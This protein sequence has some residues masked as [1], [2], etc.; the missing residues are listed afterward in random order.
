[1]TYV[2]HTVICSTRP[3]RV[4]SAIGR[5]AHQFALDH[6]KFQAEL[7]DLAAFNLP[8]FDEPAHPRLRQYKHEHTQAWSR[9]VQSADAFVFVTPE[10]NSGPPPSL[11]NALDYLVA[12]WQ[13]KPASFVA[14]GGISGGLRGTQL[15]KPIMSTLKMMVV[16]ESVV[17]P[18]VASAVDPETGFKAN[19]LHL[20]SAK[21]MLDELYRWAVALKTLRSA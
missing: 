17:V 20:E 19:N 8:V 18:T 11:V 1:M 15:L 9:S 4:G 14:Y 6:G 5:W 12:E 16:P 3:G 2:L 10:Y 7:V 21:A 13:Y